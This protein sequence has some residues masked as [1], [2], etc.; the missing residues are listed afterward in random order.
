MK[1]NETPLWC[2]VRVPR[3]REQTGR[4]ACAAA[5]GRLAAS[6]APRGRRTGGGLGARAQSPLRTAGA[7]A[8]RSARATHGRGGGGEWR[9]RPPRVAVS[10][11]KSGISPGTEGRCSRGH[12]PS[13]APWCGVRCAYGVRTVRAC[14]RCARRRLFYARCS[15]R[16]TNQSAQGSGA[17]TGTIALA[18]VQ[19]GA[20]LYATA[21]PR[22][23]AS[24][25]KRHVRCCQAFTSATPGYSR[26]PTRKLAQGAAR[27]AGERCCWPL[28]GA[29]G[30]TFYQI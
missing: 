26:W 10:L 2:A 29:P 16:R 18:C 22:A 28:H 15:A 14:A 7:G 1:N 11:L 9:R 19:C 8:W 30:Q 27:C 21:K 24:K 6:G 17:Q 4:R 20:R 5:C 23:A 3:K 25:V 13:P 12:P